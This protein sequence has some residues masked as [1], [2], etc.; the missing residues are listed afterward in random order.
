MAIARITLGLILVAD[1]ILE[2]QPADY[3]VFSSFL[4]ASATALPGPLAELATWAAGVLSGQTAAA[5]GVLA[6]LETAFGVSWTLGLYT[7]ATLLAGIPVFLGVWLFGE[8]LGGAFSPGATDLSAGPLYVLCCLALWAGASWRCW[9]LD[10]WLGRS[11][12]AYRRSAVGAAAAALLALLAATTWSALVVSGQPG[13]A[14]PAPVGAAAMAMDGQRNVDLLYGGCG[15]LVCSHQTW[16][17]DGR[18]WSLQAT[19]PGLPALGYASMAYFP[20]L[21]QVV[22]FGGAQLQGTV[23]PSGA[24][25][26]WDGHW[27][28]FRGGSEPPARRFA[29]LAYDP[30]SQQLIL[31]G[32]DTAEARP[33]GDTWVFNRSGW[34]RLHPLRSPSPRAAAAMAWDPHLGKLVL[35]GGNGSQGRLGD[36]WAW[37]AD[38]WSRLR[39][40]NSPPPLAYESMATDP[41]TGT[42]LLYS[43]VSAGPTTWELKGGSWRPVPTAGEAQPPVSSFEILAPAPDKRGVLLF[44]GASSSSSSYFSHQLWLWGGKGWVRLGR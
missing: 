20:P 4:T 34:H 41:L 23:P 42:A 43:G 28:R 13:I 7:R 9:S 8:G 17:W 11:S 26:I 22:M 12:R 14:G 18:S 44:G 10:A 16:I 35:F 31:F 19:P 39:P 27:D 29:A 36:T 40:Q 32:G 2:W 15:Y 37:G 33:L 38:G 25:W 3:Q 24:T 21:H 6:A 30:K 5:N 1:A